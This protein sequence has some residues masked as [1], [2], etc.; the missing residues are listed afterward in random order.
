VTST[1]F[2]PFNRTAEKEAQAR[3]NKALEPMVELT[4][5]M[6]SYINEA[7]YFEDDP[8]KTFWGDNYGRLLRIKRQV[9]PMNVLWC[10]F[11]VGHEHWQ[12]RANGQLCTV[13]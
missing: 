6:G 11:C 9:D 5:G 13:S 8:A 1:S 2:E 4:P 3:M 12:Q 7:A 10:P